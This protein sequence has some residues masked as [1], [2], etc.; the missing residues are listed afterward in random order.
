MKTRGYKMT[1]EDI[2]LPPHLQRMVNLDMDGADIM[3][4]ELKVLMVE[5]EQQLTLAQEAEE[6]SGEAMDSMERKYWEGVLDTYV[7]LYKLTY[8]I[9]FS[10]GVRKENLKDGH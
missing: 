2:G 1:P 9:A 4:G 8:D 10:K 7:E 5:A 3:H 6:E